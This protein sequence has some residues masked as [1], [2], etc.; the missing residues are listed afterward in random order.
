LRGFYRKRLEG[1]D[2]R[3]SVLQGGLMKKKTKKLV[4]A[5]E[6]VRGLT[7]HLEMVRGASAYGDCYPTQGNHPCEV[8]D[9]QHPTC[10]P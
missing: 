1:G 10:N 9:T 4:L 8:V 2:G 7:N 3:L 5:K 6:T